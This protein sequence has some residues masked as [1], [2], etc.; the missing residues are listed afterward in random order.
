MAD[1]ATT[2]RPGVRALSK[3]EMLG[4]LSQLPLLPVILILSIGF[5]LAVPRLAISINADTIARVFA[6]LLIASSG[7]A[8]V[9][10]TGGIDLSVG[11]VMSLASVLGS[12][13]GSRTR[14]RERAPVRIPRTQLCNGAVSETRNATNPDG[15][16][17]PSV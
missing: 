13:Q 9:M 16:T 1:L 7:A 10:L 12:D 8:F 6:P 15:V 2:T 17:G 3:R 4:V 14:L 11:A 5:S